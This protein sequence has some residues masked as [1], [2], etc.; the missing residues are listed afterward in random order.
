M[1]KRCPNSNC[2]DG[3]I[4]CDE[5]SG[6]GTV[7][8]LFGKKDC[9]KCSGTGNLSCPECQICPDCDGKGKVSWLIACISCSS[10]GRIDKFTPNQR[11]DQ[12]LAQKQY[13]KAKQYYLEAVKENDKD[14]M[15]SL[16]VMYQNGLGVPRIT[17]TANEWFEKSRK[18][19]HSG[20][21]QALKAYNK[22]QW[23]KQIY[24]CKG[25][26]TLRTDGIRHETCSS[27]TSPGLCWIDIVNF[28]VRCDKCKKIWPLE[29]GRLTCGACG[30]TQHVDYSKEILMV[31]S[32]EKVVH[33]DGDMVYKIDH[34]GRLIIGRHTY[35]GSG[36]LK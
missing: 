11:G 30:H 10:T 29:A 25:C 3:N 31:N 1:K 7:G 8:I 36:Y 19:G 32:N 20:A 17:K 9:Q 18:R 28:E 23:K 16:G 5:C 14:A 13:D 27:K 21:K 12:A 2:K 15:Y 6:K 4:R 33:Q 24:Y 26:Q 22:P 35:R 34:S